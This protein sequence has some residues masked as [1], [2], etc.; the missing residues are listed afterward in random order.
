MPEQILTQ[1]RLKELLSYNPDTGIFTRKI[2]QGNTHA[3]EIAGHPD[4]E[5][6]LLV[7]IDYVRYKAHRLS[8]LYM[9]GAFPVCVDHINHICDDNRWANIRDVSFSVNQRNRMKSKNNSSGITGVYW[10]KSIKKWLAQ[11]AIHSKSIHL[12]YYDEKWDAICSRK[13]AEAKNGFL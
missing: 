7:C 12:G 1:E 13:S 11:I 4:K 5:G 3:G 10:K 9:T 6:Y 2:D 8:F